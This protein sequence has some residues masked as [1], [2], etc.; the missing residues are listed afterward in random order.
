MEDSG[1]LPELV[2]RGRSGQREAVRDR[3]MLRWIARFR[4]VDSEVLAERFGTSRQQINARV[5]RLERAGLL[6][7]NTHGPMPAWTIAATSRGLAALGLPPRRAARTTV[8]REH[9][10]A[11]AAIVAR[12]ERTRPESTVHT[13]RDCRRREAASRA[14][15]SADVTDP[16]QGRSRR[17]PDLVLEDDDRRVAVEL[18][19]TPK[20]IARLRRIVAAYRNAPWFDEVRFLTPD[21]AIMQ[22]LQRITADPERERARALFAKA[23]ATE[24]AIRILDWPDDGLG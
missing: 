1:R 13:E 5:R 16:K 17:W 10:L 12:H 19:L 20:G 24:P 8:Q 9:E 22:R 2:Q 4:F 23:A 6:Q 3:E 15:F 18:E 21:P 14:R 7:R 11:L